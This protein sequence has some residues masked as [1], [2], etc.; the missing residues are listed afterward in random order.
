VANTSYSGGAGISRSTSDPL[1]RGGGPPAWWRT[2]D[3]VLGGGPP[4]CRPTQGIG[5]V[6]RTSCSAADTRQE[7]AREEGDGK[8]RGVLGYLHILHRLK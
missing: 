4:A 7:E 1:Q 2:L 6:R 3:T 5:A 8:G